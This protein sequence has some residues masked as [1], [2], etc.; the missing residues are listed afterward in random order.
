MQNLQWT[1]S[2]PKLAC[3]LVTDDNGETKE[4]T[5]VTDTMNPT[6]KLKAAGNVR[7]TAKA[8]DGSGKFDFVNLKITAP[9]TELTITPQLKAG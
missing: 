9:V 1:V 2:N 8:V 5:T 7:I 3:F 6:L 4:A